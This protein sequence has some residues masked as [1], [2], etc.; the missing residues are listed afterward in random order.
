MQKNP[1]FFCTYRISLYYFIAL[2]K[3]FLHFILLSP[4]TYQPRHFIEREALGTTDGEL[5]VS[6]TPYSHNNRL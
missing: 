2:H 6:N 5:L 1:L 3:Y 4:L